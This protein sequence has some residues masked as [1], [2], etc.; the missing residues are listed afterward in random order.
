MGWECEDWID[1]SQDR[2]KGRGVV[3]MAMDVRVT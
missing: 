1:M 3:E 2:D